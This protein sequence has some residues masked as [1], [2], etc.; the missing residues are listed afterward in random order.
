MSQ[1]SFN[2]VRAELFEALGH[3]MRVTIL[4][5]LESK[6]LGFAEIKKSVGI[7][8]SGHLQFHLRKLDGLVEDSPNGAYA[9]TSDG[10][11][12]LRVFRATDVGTARERSISSRSRKNYLTVIAALGTLAIVLGSSLVLGVMSNVSQT[13]SLNSQLNSQR[14]QISSL[15]NQ[16]NS[17]K[18]QISSLQSQT[19]SLQSQLSRYNQTILAA[20]LFPTSS[21]PASGNC[22]YYA[23]G[24]YANLGLRTAYSANVT[25]YF[26][27]SSGEPICSVFDPLGTVGAQSLYH[28]TRFGCSGAPSNSTILNWVFN[29]S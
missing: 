28:F 5:A 14:D 17:Q 27:T 13:S 2:E 20:Y 25:L 21:C 1:D 24:D 12:A 16:L 4:E 19:I 18:S 22:F 6:P 11:D 15:N 3:P 9:L 8:S 23:N 26:Q 7:E 10:R 29:W